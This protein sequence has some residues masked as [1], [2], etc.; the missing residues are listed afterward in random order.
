MDGRSDHSA[1]DRCR[2][3]LHYVRADARLPKNRG[4]TRQDGTDGHEFGSKA[5]HGALNY[6][7]LDV[8]LRTDLARS[9]NA[10][11]VGSDGVER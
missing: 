10:T 3:W 2:D 11:V 1:N 5:L 7:S 6:C 9:H 4:E 8:L